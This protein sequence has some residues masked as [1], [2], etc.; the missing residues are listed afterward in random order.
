[1]KV[2]W[3]IF[4][5]VFF[6]FSL[7]SL[8]LGWQ[9]SVHQDQVLQTAEQATATLVDWVPD[10]NYGTPDFC[11][12]YEFTTKSG[13]VVDDTEVNSCKSEPDLS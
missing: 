2:F 4:G 1:M 7:L 13:E 11:P 10:P 12:V 6:I 3:W 5:S 9:A 8:F